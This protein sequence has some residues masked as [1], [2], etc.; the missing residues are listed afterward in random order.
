MPPDLRDNL[1]IGLP[2]N[3]AQTQRQTSGKFRLN[4]AE[5]WATPGGTTNSKVPARRAFGQLGPIPSKCRRSMRSAVSFSGIWLRGGAV[6]LD[7]EAQG[8]RLF[9]EKVP[10]SLES[11]VSH[12]DKLPADLQLTFGPATTVSVFVQFNSRFYELRDARAPWEQNK[13]LIH[14]ERQNGEYGFA[15]WDILSSSILHEIWLRL[16]PLRGVPACLGALPGEESAMVFG[17]CLTALSLVLQATH[18]E[19]PKYTPL[20]AWL[21]PS[22]NQWESARQDLGLETV[23]RILHAA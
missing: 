7:A 1:C 2:H 11:T 12:T 13:K 5:W 6:P 15:W 14:C 22:R 17:N 8:M 4:D 23:C 18:A 16:T 20:S 3:R 10:M 9:R 19:S 21:S